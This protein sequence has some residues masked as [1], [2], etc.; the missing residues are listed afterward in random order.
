MTTVREALDHARRKFTAVGIETAALD[1]RLLAEAVTGLRH[2][3]IIADPGR[4]IGPEA[5]EA[6]LRM[7]ARRQSHEPVSRILGQREFYGRIF[8]VTSAVLDPRPDTETL[9]GEALKHMGPGSRV[10]DLGTGSGAIIITLLAECPDA[11]GVATDLSAAAIALAQRNAS[12]LGVAE[13]LLWI[14]SNWFEAVTGRFGLIVS[15]PPYIPLSDFAKLPLAVRGFD[16]AMAL[17]GGPDGLEA[18]RRIAAGAGAHLAP[19]GR[20]L[21][22]IGWG[23]T[24]TVE[25]IFQGAGFGLAASVADL[26]GHPRCLIFYPS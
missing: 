2:E 11:T 1:A 21:V 4:E 24:K 23:M 5:S 9:V 3:E 22:E 13:R 12:R 26:A 25:T 17:D 10:L 16:P 7:V 8:Q 14:Q 15:N 20:I 19:E 6:F 18:Y